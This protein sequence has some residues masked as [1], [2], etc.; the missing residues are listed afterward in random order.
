[1]FHFP[2]DAA[3]RWR[4]PPRVAPRPDKTPRQ[5]VRRWMGIIPLTSSTV[6]QLLSFVKLLFA[7]LASQQA[8][9]SRDFSTGAPTPRGVGLIVEETGTQGTKRTKGKN[10]AL[11]NMLIWNKLQNEF[12]ESSQKTQSRFVSNPYCGFSSNGCLAATCPP[13][14]LG[15][16]VRL[17]FPSRFSEGDARLERAAGARDQTAK[18]SRKSHGATRSTAARSRVMRALHA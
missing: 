16:C 4:V 3:V 14:A 15:E 11:R 12:L 2:R 9:R 5:A 17:P 7:Y 10:I 1:M 13:S 18:L 8:G 6:A